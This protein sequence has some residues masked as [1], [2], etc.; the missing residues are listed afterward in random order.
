MRASI[1]MGLA[2][3]VFVGGGPSLA[4]AS[5]DVPIDVADT[6][7]TPWLGCWHLSEEQLAEWAQL[8]D[9]APPIEYTSVCVAPTGDG[10]ILTAAVRDDVLVS[11]RLIA[12]GVKHPINDESCTGWERSEWSRDG[13]R[14]F[15]SGKVEC[16]DEPKRQVTG[17]SFMASTTNWVDIQLVTLA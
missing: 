7:W 15:T 10:V 1:R 6:R 9:D 17:V 8:R 3:L 2:A 4:T 12:D 11:R 14:L 13:Q 5:Q 16:A